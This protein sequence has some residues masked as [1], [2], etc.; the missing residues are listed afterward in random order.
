[1][2][3]SVWSTASLADAD[4]FPY[5]R[6]VV[7]EAFTP[8]EVIPLHD[9]AFVGEVS[10]ARMG[11]LQVARITSQA[12][13]VVRTEA[14]VKRQPGDS[15]F[16]NLPL[17]A[18]LRAA[19][20]GRTAE[21]EPGDFTII[22]GAEPFRLDFAGDF[23]QISVLV[24]REMLG[25]AFGMPPC[26]T[27]WRVPGARGIGAVASAVIRTLAEE[28][29]HLNGSEA[30]ALAGWLTGL[31]ALAVASVAPQVPSTNRTLLLQAVMDAAE[32][33]LSDP[34]LSPATVAEQIGISTRY[35]HQ[36]S[37]T[38]GQRSASGCFIAGSSVADATSATLA[39][40]TVRS[41]KSPQVRD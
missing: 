4:Q 11:P 24:P 20:R 26:P 19:Q 1:M 36:L 18:G 39:M 8:V 12:Q 5:W 9:G 15:Y 23:T 13:T 21:L 30:T 27:A 38:A 37:L 14:L 34:Q 29:D 33:S 16:V 32:R 3:S 40:G 6:D 2:A 31:L 25:P 35:L 17:T 41:P 10:L 28:Q 7:W 22:D